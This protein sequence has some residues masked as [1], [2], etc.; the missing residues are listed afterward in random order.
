[1][2]IFTVSIQDFDKTTLS[3]LLDQIEGLNVDVSNILI[4]FDGKIIY[5]KCA[6]M[7]DEDDIAM[8]EKKLKRSL[9]NLKL[10]PFCILF[11]D[12]QF[13]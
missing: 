6:E 10:Q 5:E 2:T 4:E 7:T 13:K 11:L 3:D 8:N 1:L 12:G 9:T